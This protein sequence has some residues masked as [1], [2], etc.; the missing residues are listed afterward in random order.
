MNRIPD[1]HRSPVCTTPVGVKDPLLN[2]VSPIAPDRD[3]V[4]QSRATFGLCFDRAILGSGSTL[5][6]NSQRG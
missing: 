1:L 2:M 3:R 6:R 5:A 4:V